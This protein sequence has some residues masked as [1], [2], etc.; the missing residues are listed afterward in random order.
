[1]DHSCQVQRLP[2]AERGVDLYETPP[3]APEALASVEKIPHM[4]W[5]PAAG[6][7]AIVRVLR[8]HG[9]AIIASDLIDYGGLHFARDFPGEIGMTAGVEAIVTNPPFKLAEAFVEHALQ[10]C[11]LVIILLRL[12]FLESERRCSILENRGL[13]RVHVFQKAPPDDAPH[14]LGRAQSKQRNGFCLV[15]LG[16]H[17]RWPHHHQQDLVGTITNSGAAGRSRGRAVLCIRK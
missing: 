15:R 3:V 9:H 1:L 14:G 7:G 16:P 8:A 17:A 13:A 2:H 11:P 12:A 6:P 10:L 5:E 4:V